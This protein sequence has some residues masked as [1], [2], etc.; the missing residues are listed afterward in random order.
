MAF[1]YQNG[2]PFWDFVASFDPEGSTHPFKDNKDAVP[3]GCRRGRGFGGPRGGFHGRGGHPACGGRNR[4][5]NED[6]SF[7]P[8]VDIFE[9]PSKYDIHVSLP[10]SQ[11]TDIGLDWD[12]ENGTLKIA[13]VI[14]R[15]GGEE[16]LKTITNV[17]ERR[18]GLFERKVKLEKV[19]ADAILAKLEDGVLRIEVPKEEKEF[20]VIKKIDVE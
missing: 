16:F 20:D 13:G 11:K 2:S 14:H 6:G 1:V 18:T 9:S 10:G 17:A 7:R 4:F 15:P 8:A 12:Q 5:T 3:E 19:D